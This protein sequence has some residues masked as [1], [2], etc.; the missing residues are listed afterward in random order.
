MPTSWPPCCSARTAAPQY[1]IGFGSAA[2]RLRVRAAARGG[3]GRRLRIFAALSAVYRR[4]RG[5]YA[6]VALIIGHGIVGFRD[7]H[8]IRPLVL[9]SARHP[10]AE[11]MVASESVALDHASFR[12]AA[13]RR[14]RRGAVHRR[15]GQCIQQCGPEHHRRAS[16][17]TSI[18]LGRIRSSTTSRCTRPACAWARPWPRRSCASDRPRHRRGDPHPDTSRTTALEMAQ[19]LGVKYRKVSSRT[20]TSAAP[21]SCRARSSARSRC[22][23]AQRHRSGIPRQERA[24]GR[25]FDRAWHHLRADHRVAREA[26]AKNVYFASAAPPVRHPNVYGIDMPAAC[27]LVAPGAASRK[28]RGSSARTG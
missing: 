6:V 4:C 7:P 3:G 24:A 22:A 1:R 10:R 15:T 5:G 8:G 25:R 28:W 11:Y 23:Q 27:E 19:R 18:S 20:A 16:S 26:G 2:Q 9:G 14:S 21:S 12:S 13:R 17:S